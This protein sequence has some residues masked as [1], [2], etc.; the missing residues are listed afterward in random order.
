MAPL[1]DDKINSATSWFLGLFFSD[2]DE[3]DAPAKDADDEEANERPQPAE[4]EEEWEASV[5]GGERKPGRLVQ[6]K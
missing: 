3:D 6:C 5:W 1:T 4:H 2:L